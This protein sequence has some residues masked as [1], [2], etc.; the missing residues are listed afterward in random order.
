[1]LRAQELCSRNGFDSCKYV[2][3]LKDK[4]NHLAVK[5]KVYCVWI[6]YVPAVCN[7]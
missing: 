3:E 7:A 4:R 1:M 5:L 6:Y 2:Y